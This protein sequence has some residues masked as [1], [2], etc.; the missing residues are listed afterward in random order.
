MR[1]LLSAAVVSVMS[2]SRLN[3]VH[4]NDMKPGPLPHFMEQKDATADV[5]CFDR[6]YG[7]SCLRTEYV[8]VHSML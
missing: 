3:H 8:P 6:V 7:V 5:T 4:R 1:A 2:N